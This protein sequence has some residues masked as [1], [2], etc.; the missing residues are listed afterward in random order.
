MGGLMDY[1]ARFYSPML[2]R[3]IQPDSLIPDAQNPQ[4]WNRFS[5]GLN[6]PSRYTDP[7]G[8]MP[9]A[10]C[11]DDGSSDCYASE[12]EIT[13]NI[14]R[15]ADFRNETNRRKCADGN[16]NYCGESTAKILAFTATALTG[17]VLAETAILGGGAAATVDAALWSLQKAAWKAGWKLLQVCAGIPAC[18]EYAINASIYYPPNGGA[19]TTPTP[20]TLQP[21]QIITRIG[22]EAGHYVSPIGT[23]IAQRALP[24]HQWS[25]QLSGYQVLKPI[26]V[27][28]SEAAPYYGLPGGGIQYYFSQPIQYYIKNGYLS[29]SLP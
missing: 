24:F 5:Y 27:L 22:D 4:A 8:H 26:E 18:R 15:D 10:G 12:N 14:R 29:Q 21:D 2:G 3:F 9:V 7:S 1:K 16:K 25:V 17:G 20:M 11:G 23:T 19:A 6:N 28:S 13:L